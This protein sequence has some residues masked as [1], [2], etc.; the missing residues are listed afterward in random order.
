MGPSPISVETERMRRSALLAFVLALAC[1]GGATAASAHA[2]AAGATASAPPPRS[3][4][5]RGEIDSLGADHAAEH[6]RLRAEMRIERA[7]PARVRRAIALEERRAYVRVTAQDAQADGSWDPPFHTPSFAMHAALLPTGKVL[8]FGF[9]RDPDRFGYAGGNTAEAWLWDPSKGTDRAAYQNVDPPLVDNNG[10]GER[11]APLYCSGFAF[12]GNGALVLIGGNRNLGNEEGGRWVFTFDPFSEL[13]HEQQSTLRGRWYPTVVER[14]DGRVVVMAGWTEAGSDS[15]NTDFEIFPAL[16]TPVPAAT[17]DGRGAANLPVG[18][19]ALLDRQTDLYP[20][21]FLL[22]SGKLSIVGPA[23]DDSAVTSGL[24][25]DPAS[26][27]LNIDQLPVT[28]AGNNNRNGGN[29]VLLPGGPDGSD[30]VA[31]VGGFALGL[32]TNPKPAAAR[33][34]KIT[35]DAAT[36]QWQTHSTL[37]FG[38]DQ[39]NTVLLPDGSMAAIGGSPAYIATENADDEVGRRNGGSTPAEREAMLSPE[40]YDPASGTWRLGPPQTYHR[41]YHSVAL[42]LPDGSILSAGDEIHEQRATADAP[43]WVG[44]AEVY[45]PAYLY[46]G[47]RPVL[48]AAPP[49]IPYAATFPAQTPDAATV[50]R[51]VLM[52]PSA[53][54]HAEDSTQRHVELRITGRTDDTLTLRSPANGA[55]APPGYYM[56]FLLRNGVPSVAKFVRLGTTG[57]EPAQIIAQFSPWKAPPVVTTPTGTIPPASQPNGTAM[58]LGRP[59]RL[60]ARVRSQRVALRWRAVVGATSYT[61]LRD[62]KPAGTVKVPAA[63][64][65]GL[66]PD[67]GYRLTVVARDWTGTLSPVSPVLSLRTLSRLTITK[68]RT[69]RRGIVVQVRASRPVTVNLVAQVAGKIA[70]RPARIRATPAGALLLVPTSEGRRA[71]VAAPWL[72]PSRWDV[73]RPTPARS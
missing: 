40:L 34:D 1:S 10:T 43:F 58:P 19:I 71:T 27:W 29:A 18:H 57:I 39:Q 14:P 32:P 53:T 35:P 41:T 16:A 50:D 36:P 67:R 22:K 72:G 24:L 73:V 37:N 9:T 46:S 48:E 17:P 2:P 65:T 28:D 44:T 4:F 15:Y 52:A 8:L 49:Q 6:R 30:T 60:T 38:R 54:T 64:L 42:M 7:L 25:E 55:I 21:L 3:A 61:V 11:P 51:A 31:L 69:T 23:G 56:L 45:R 12:A 59:V 20:H 47:T 70:G 62:G 33:V 66:E 68:L 63:T 13:W 26:T 5:E